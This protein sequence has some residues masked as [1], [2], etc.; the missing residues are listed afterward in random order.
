MKYNMKNFPLKVNQQGIDITLMTTP[1]L[2]K[3]DKKIIKIAEWK[4]G[5]EKEL[6]EQLVYGEKA[7]KA[8]RGA[9]K[10]RVDEEIA[11]EWQ[12]S[13]RK[14]KEILGEGCRFKPE[15]IKS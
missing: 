8:W 7:E 1:E 12:G 2:S 11:M 6:R 3:D 10:H 13:N 15:E 4:V 5:F 14:I 9:R